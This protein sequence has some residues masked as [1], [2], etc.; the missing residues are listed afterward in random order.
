MG[1]AHTV[2]TGRGMRKDY[3]VAVP[4]VTVV[5]E[6]EGKRHTL[7][8]PCRGHCRAVKLHTR[9]ATAPAGQLKESGAKVYRG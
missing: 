7:V 1:P 5:A 4:E 3:P 8:A 2:I 6:T 9:I